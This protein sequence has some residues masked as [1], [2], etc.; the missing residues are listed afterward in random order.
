MVETPE[1]KPKNLPADEKITPVMIYTTNSLVRGGLITKES[2]RVCVWLRMAGAP[3]FIHLKNA[4]VIQFGLSLNSQNFIDYF[5]STPLV[6]AFHLVPP[7]EEPL[8]YDVTE[9]NRKMESVV[10]MVGSFRFSGTI[11]MS[12]S[13]DLAT[14]LAIVHTP[15][16]SIY[17]IEITNPNLQAMGV[18][19]VPFALV[20]TNQVTFGVRA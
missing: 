19:K 8:D 4:N 9:T 6:N 5:I 15:L 18:I 20:R 17:D 10:V 12:A 7:A 13:S 2:I 16:L 11:R 3:E 1:A 14:H